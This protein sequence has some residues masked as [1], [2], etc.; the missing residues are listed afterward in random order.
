MFGGGGITPDYIIKSE[1]ASTQYV[2]IQSKVGFRNFALRYMDEHGKGIHADYGKDVK[3]FVGDF[4]VKDEVV[5]QF[6][7]EAKKHGVA[8]DPAQWAKDEPV[9]KARL[10]GEFARSIWGN[11]GLWRVWQK[12]DDAQFQKAL[13]LFPEAEKIAGIR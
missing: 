13:T 8:I 4:T 7:S 1:K 3:R 2:Q 11:E 9:I 12:G 6:E 5:R 10:K